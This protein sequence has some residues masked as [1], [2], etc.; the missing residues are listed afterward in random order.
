MAEIRITKTPEAVHTGVREK[1]ISID[2]SE[3]M[4]FFDAHRF[5]DGLFSVFIKKLKERLC[6]C[7]VRNLCRTIIKFTDPYS[8]KKSVLKED[9]DIEYIRA[10]K[11]KEERR[12]E[13]CR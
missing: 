10:T 7:R 5:G 8:V 6:I 13:A 11:I 9:G 1:T 4:C 3:S 2:Q 12:C